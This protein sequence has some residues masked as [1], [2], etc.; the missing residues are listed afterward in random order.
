MY[1]H[2]GQDTVVKTEN[3]IGIF[4]MDTTTVSKRTRDFL[5]TAEKNKSVINVAV[6]DL[7]KSFV[8]CNENGKSIVYISPISSQTLLKRKENIRKDMSLWY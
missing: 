8:I 6:Y 3:I 1:L 4:D 7:P 2:I 5:N